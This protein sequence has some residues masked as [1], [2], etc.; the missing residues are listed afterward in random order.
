M[1]WISKKECT[2]D[3]CQ[4][5]C[6]KSTELQKYCGQSMQWNN[7]QQ[8]HL[9]LGTG[10]TEVLCLWIYWFSYIMAMYFG[11]MIYTT[12]SQL[13]LSSTIVNIHLVSC[14]ALLSEVNVCCHMGSNSCCLI[15]SQPTHHPS[16]MLLHLW[17]ASALFQ[18]C[19]ISN[20]KAE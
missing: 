2:E 7:Y 5:F 12:N 17:E 9:D 13:Y 1:S 19:C 16:W 18:N 10:L 11:W 3:W 14:Q 6:P 8:I 20:A 4:R 15:K